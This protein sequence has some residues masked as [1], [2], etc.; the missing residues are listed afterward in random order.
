MTQLDTEWAIK[1][2]TEFLSVTDQIPYTNRPGSGVIRLG[3]HQRGSESDAA[4]LAHVVEK[5]LDRVIPNWPREP[6]EKPDPKKP[7]S[8]W[9]HLREWTSRAKAALEREE[10]LSA[11]L[12]DDAPRL[13]AGKLHP[14]VWQAA[15]SL[16]RT[17]HYRNAVSQAALQIN[18]EAQSKIDRR[19]VSE[20]SLFD[21]VFSVADPK[22]LEP[23]LR[24]MDNDGSKT[25]ASVHRGAASFAEGLY[26]T[27]RNP[28]SHL[29]QEELPEQEALE[30]LAAWSLLARL[31][32]QA[33]L[34][35]A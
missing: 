32:D 20:K 10:E 7:G 22:P 13:D 29:V 31:V 23:R 8:N 35:K 12:G 28:N 14:W 26:A 18:A 5:I 11:K 1:Q 25:F 6:A 19:D 34:V 21:N 17:G 33:K 9:V 4:G 3:S 24:L 27:Y 2:I 15:Q 30:Q 16:W